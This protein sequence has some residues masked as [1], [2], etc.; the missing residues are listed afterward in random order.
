MHRVGTL[1]IL[2]HVCIKCYMSMVC[3]VENVIDEECLIS[4]CVSFLVHNTHKDEK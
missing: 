4:K 2:F 3:M 1:N